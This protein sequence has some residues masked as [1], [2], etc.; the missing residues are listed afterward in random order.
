M[1]D[2]M[3]TNQRSVIKYIFPITGLIVG[4]GCIRRVGNLSGV[5]MRDLIEGALYSD[6]TYAVLHLLALVKYIICGPVYTAVF[7]Y[8]RGSI[9]TLATIL[10]P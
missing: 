7:H 8:E 2:A 10:P 3:I 1:A 5:K 4:Q 9:G 6:E